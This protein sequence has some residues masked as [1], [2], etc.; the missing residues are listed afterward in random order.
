MKRPAGR[1]IVRLG[2]EMI[3]SRDWKK[4]EIVELKIP[5]GSRVLISYPPGT[6]FIETREIAPSQSSR[7]IIIQLS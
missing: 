7:V 2:K 1:I 4:E 6:E 3:E 5:E